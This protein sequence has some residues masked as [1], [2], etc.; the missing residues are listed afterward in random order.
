MRLT[1]ATKSVI[2]KMSYE[3]LLRRW[4]FH[5][6]G[7]SWFEGETGEYW[8]ARI[9]ELRHERPGGE[10]AHV[11]ASKKIGWSPPNTV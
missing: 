4:R 9:A 3:E 10:E 6:V 11:Q 7:A 8:A 2:D 1:E 5:S